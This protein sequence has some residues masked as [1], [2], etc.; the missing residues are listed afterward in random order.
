MRSDAL[1][2]GVEAGGTK[3]N[4][5]VGSG[6]DS[7]EAQARIPTTTPAETLQRVIHFFKPYVQIGRIRSLAI[8]SFGPVDLNK[9]S[10]T[11]GWITSTPKP[12][13]RNVDVL[14]PL[15]S[16]LQ[17][18]TALDTDVN[19]AALGEV[20]WGAGRGA[21]PVLYL[22]I[23]TGIG[24]GLIDGGR[25]FQGL[26]HPEMGHIRIPHDLSVDDFPGNCPFHNDCFEGLANGPAIQRRLGQPADTLADD[27]PFWIIEAGY[28]SAALAVYILVLSPARIIL[29]GGVMQRR[30]MFPAIRQGVRG[31]L[32]GYVE[33]PELMEH[34]DEY[35]VPPQLGS[36]S[37]VLGAL[38]LARQSVSRS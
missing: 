14:G 29:G 30:F 19:V 8:G 21:A 4:C 33:L 13:W 3:F 16:A 12:G 23:G 26:S 22:T 31:N 35:I 6:P 17:L 28:I 27:H 37:G 25:A 18:P 20:T 7:I 15:K 38:A 10:P 1:Y 32:N 24:G 2:G 5:I 11:Y 9:A 36:Q 34:I